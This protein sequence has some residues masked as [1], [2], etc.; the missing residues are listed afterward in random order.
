MTGVT[1]EY[2]TKPNSG[3]S[4]VYVIG[5][6]GG[7]YTVLWSGTPEEDHFTATFD[8]FSGQLIIAV[9]GNNPVLSLTTLK[10]YTA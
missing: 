10:L 5:L 9:A 3:V 1:V 8:S 2:A 4:K 6:A 7:N